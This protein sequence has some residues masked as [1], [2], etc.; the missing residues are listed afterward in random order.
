MIFIVSTVINIASDFFHILSPLQMDNK[1]VSQLPEVTIN[2]LPVVAN[3]QRIKRREF[4][5][6]DRNAILQFLLRKELNGKLPPGAIQSA[7]A[8]FDCNRMTISRIWNRGIKSYADGNRCANVNS[9]KKTNCGRKRKD[10]SANLESMRTIKLNQRSNL[11]SLSFAIGIPKTTLFNIFK[12]GDKIKRVSSTLKPYLTEDNK[13]ERV[14]FCLSMIQPNRRF[15]D[16]QD[17][18]HIDEKW[19]YVTQIKRSYYLL[20][21]EEVPHRTTKSKR[22]ITKVIEPEK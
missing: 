9:L 3:N 20:M 17:Y 16:F 10:F 18:V 7:A 8:E 21:D 22:F 13:R 6:E 4:S 14:R 15:V 12:R 5:N 11:R 19:F 1:L 2:A